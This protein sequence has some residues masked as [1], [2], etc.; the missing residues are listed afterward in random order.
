MK[1]FHTYT[2]EYTQELLKADKKSGLK[3]REAKKRL[4]EN[5]KNELT[6]EKSKSIISRFI[7]QLNDFLIIILIVAAIVSFVI[8]ILQGEHDLTEP[9]II[10]A[11][12]ILNA[13][14][15]VFQ[16]GRAEKS[17]KMLKK[18]SAPEAC[19]LR[20]GR[21]IKIPA[22][23]VVAGDI[24]VFSTGDIVAADARIIDGVNIMTDE[25]A[26]TGES[27]PVNKN[28]DIVL[29]EDI[30][31]GDKCNMIFASTSVVSG[32][33]RAVV[34]DTGMNTEV[35]RVAGLILNSETPQTPLQKRMA[36]F[37][38]KIGIIA[39][40][41]CALVFFAGV[42]SG[43]SFLEMFITSVS[44]AV[45]A[46]PEGLPAIVTIMLALGVSDMAKHKALVRN[47]PSVETLGSAGV[48]CTDKTGTITENKMT[49]TKTFTKDENLLC[50]LGSLCCMKDTHNP[51]EL[52]IIKY[53]EDK[54]K[55]LEKYRILKEIP[56]S[57]RLKKMTVL[58]KSG[59]ENRIICKGA[60]DVL[61]N[62]CTKYWNGKGEEN[63]DF[64]KK[65]EILKEVEK[66]ADLGLR[67]I[68][69]SYK[70][71]TD[72]EILEKN[73]VFL[74]VFG[75]EDPPRKEAK[76]A[77]EVCRRAKI[78]PV[79]I[80]GDHL[81]TAVA[82]ARK[83]GIFEDGKKAIT[84]SELDV[85][86]DEELKESIND[87]RVFARVSP[88]HKVR[89]VKA[90]QE[91]GEV[92]AMTG[93]GVNDAPALKCADIGCSLGLSGTDVAK[94]AS[95]MVLCDD[96]FATVVKAVKHGR[97]I[98]KNIKKT[99]RFLLSSNTGEIVTIF[100]GML[101][102]FP[103]PLIAIQLLWVNLVTD[104]LPA[105]ALGVDPEDEDLMNE[106]P[107]KASLFSKNMIFSVLFE[108][109]M[110]GMLALLA[111]SIGMFKFL[112]INIA[113]TMSFCTLSISQLI[114]SFNMRSEKSILK[115]GL[116]KNHL[117]VFSAALGIF[118]QFLVTSVPYLAGIFKVTPLSLVQWLV[119]STLAIM[120]L[121]VV[122]IQK[123][124][125]SKTDKKINK[126]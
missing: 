70:I 80:T 2:A 117:L 44:L 109:L 86:S 18:M 120:P 13:G 22:S 5:G 32:H 57:S 14:I 1:K 61:L 63:L 98:F 30:A 46:I 66:M 73:M 89:I 100:F 93:D 68:G 121:L 118:L 65:R 91:S 53:A 125:N 72:N 6:Q 54:A 38:K 29:A 48:I 55:N 10:L 21:V 51:T 49:V 104:S 58:C 77:V 62:F 23:E 126:K 119:V 45:A 8:G 76:E 47:L 106:P 15:G 33:G 113:R 97:L 78:I 123:Y 16:E 31:I 101:M 42:F 71:T 74:G 105:I 34:T 87:Y 60:T 116:F 27:N 90:W 59:T 43:Y 124:L 56:F 19:V 50:L 24:L 84:G 95:D 40:I 92:V 82:I 81:N 122:E 67:V 11:I 83:T 35:G 26:I 111:F 12:V 75:I 112:D 88:E 96:N 107:S 20:G 28:P 3:E 9:V 99:V 25:S 94:A 103:P 4:L 7:G 115:C 110:I 39:L 114:H 37:G 64:S 102:G 17:L 108:G 36:D 41:I 85:L 52:A 69:V 79:M